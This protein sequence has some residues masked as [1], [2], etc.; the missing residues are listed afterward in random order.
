M[1]VSAVAISLEQIRRGL[2]LQQ[3][4]VH[5]KPANNMYS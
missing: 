3:A 4:G 1:E 5:G 2:V